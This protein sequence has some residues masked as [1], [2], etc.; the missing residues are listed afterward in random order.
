MYANILIGEPPHVKPNIEFTYDTNEAQE[1]ILSRLRISR[2]KLE[3]KTS[4]SNK[5]IFSINKS[6]QSKDVV[7]IMKELLSMTL[8]EKSGNEQ[9]RSIVIELEQDNEF[10]ETLLNELTEAHKLQD[11]TAEKFKNQVVTLQTELTRLVHIFT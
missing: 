5:D 8:E 11:E 1:E 2:P 7:D 3:Y 4:Y 9:R 6:N 10:F